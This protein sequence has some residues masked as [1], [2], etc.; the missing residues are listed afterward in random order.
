MR[1]FRIFTDSTTDLPAEFYE[2][3]DI[4]YISLR[5][6]IDGETFD[7]NHTVSAADF[8]NKM[9][10]GS[11]PTTTQPSPEIAEEFIRNEI[12]KKDTDILFIAFSSGLSGTYN[13]VSLAANNIM[14][15][16]PSRKIIVI[17]SLAASTGEGLI[18]YKALQYKNAGHTLEETAKYVED[19][20]LHA[21][22]VFTVDDLNSLHRGGRVSKGTAIVG[23]LA[24]IKPLLHT[25]DEGHLT[26]VG[27]T[28]GRKKSLIWLVDSM[29]KQMGSYR[30]QNDTVFICNGDC[31]DDA[32]FVKEQVMT[33][34]G[35]ENVVIADTGPVIGAHSGPGTLAL[36]F[37]GDYR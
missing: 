2:K 32:N 18:V 31:I 36:F 34:F 27:M 4:P 15:E 10:N 22:H 5:Y 9:R 29:E 21:V 23:T 8:Y 20:K 37:M 16:D 13:S 17:D 19:I 12:A 30:D 33:R 6:T 1:D 25:D 14:E 24:N 35:I 26:S 28:R 3:Y 7:D 11:T